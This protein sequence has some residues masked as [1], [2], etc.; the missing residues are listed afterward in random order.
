MKENGWDT[1]KIPKELLHVLEKSHIHDYRIISVN[2]VKGRYNLE[3]LTED[4]KK[5]FIKYNENAAAGK[6]FFEK[7]KSIYR[8]LERCGGQ[9]IP[10]I[11]WNE[12]ILATEYIQNS[13]TF[14]KWLLEKADKDMFAEYLQDIISKYKVFLLELKIS[15]VAKQIEGCDKEIRLESF[16]NKLLFSGPFGTK[17][18][19]AEKLRNKILKLFLRKYVDNIRVKDDRHLIHGDFHL[20]N[21]L[22][23]DGGVYFIDFENVSYGSVSIELAYWYVQV[24][25]LV[26]D[27]K[28][29]TDILQK[30][31]SSLFDMDFLNEDEFNKIVTLYQLA[32]LLNR[33]FHRYEHSAKHAVILQKWMELRKMEG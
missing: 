14:R 27:D 11:V 3:T 24:W 6:I 26:Y 21:I 13:S 19:K 2:N 25:M 32:I 22:V 9:F 23:S 1:G 17:T 7:E 31:T 16:F 15:L 12:H 30:Q 20:N 5:I 8:E 28:E 29:M 4:N 18:H 33:R 10:A